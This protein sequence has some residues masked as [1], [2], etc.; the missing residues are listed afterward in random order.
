[1]MSSRVKEKGLKEIQLRL[2][3]GCEADLQDGHEAMRCSKP[4]L[5][6]KNLQ[7]DVVAWIVD[8]LHGYGLSGKTQI[9]GNI[10]GNRNLSLNTSIFFVVDVVVIAQSTVF[11]LI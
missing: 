3:A 7:Q 9:V 8:P 1:M 11:C 2:K 6:L 5:C 10:Y 4:V